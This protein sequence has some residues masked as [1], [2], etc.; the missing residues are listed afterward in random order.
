M[1]LAAIAVLA[2][3]A[4]TPALAQVS[5]TNPANVKAGTYAVE[6]THTRIAFAIGHM[7]FTTWFGDF[8]TPSGKLVL[9]PAKPAAS[10]LTVTVPVG[11]VSTTN[12]KLDSELKESDWLDAA[13]Y[14]TATFTANEITATAGTA[15]VLGSL[16]LHGVTRPVMFAVKFNGAGVNPL[17]KAYTV[18]FEVQGKI[19][20]SDFGVKKYIPLVSDDV[21]LIISAAFEKK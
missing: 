17:D 2:T 10:T 20:R 5:V 1:R 9:N 19:K 7:G 16:T 14:P 18:G 11:T 15:R 3:I 12:A 13:K 8:T 4:A 21:N 6:P